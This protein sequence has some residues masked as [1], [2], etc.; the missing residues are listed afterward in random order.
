MVIVAGFRR[1]S[2]PVEVV[3]HVI[4]QISFAAAIIIIIRRA[5][6]RVFRDIHEGGIL[7][8]VRRI[9]GFRQA[10]PLQALHL[11]PE[12]LQDISPH[13]PVLEEDSV[14][15]EASQARA[16]AASE[17]DNLLGVETPAADREDA[18]LLE[19][20]VLEDVLERDGDGLL[21]ES[22]VDGD[23][24]TPRVEDGAEEGRQLLQVGIEVGR[25]LEA[26]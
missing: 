11:S 8:K 9:V 21:R 17:V 19:P 23:E 24:S 4:V 16:V 3:D 25:V 7:V 10:E 22:D 12:H 26:E 13:A 20:H 5:D 14:E 1:F 2:F 6:V 18:Q 15:T